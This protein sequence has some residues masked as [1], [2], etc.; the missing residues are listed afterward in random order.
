MELQTEQEKKKTPEVVTS[1]VFCI[2]KP[3]LYFT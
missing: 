1:G 2:Q 3:G